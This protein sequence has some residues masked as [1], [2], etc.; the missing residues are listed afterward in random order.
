MNLTSYLTFTLISF[1]ANIK[2]VYLFKHSLRSVGSSW[3]ELI[4][5]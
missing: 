5:P 4:S 3:D 1:S 2:D